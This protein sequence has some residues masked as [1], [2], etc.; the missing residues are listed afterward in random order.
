MK[1]I[2]LGIQIDNF[3]VAPHYKRYEKDHIQFIKGVYDTDQTILVGDFN[4]LAQYYPSN[5]V[6]HFD[7]HGTSSIDRMVSKRIP[8]G[9]IFTEVSVTDHL[10]LFSD[11]YLNGHVIT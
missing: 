8:S 7:N 11:F 1:L 10:A 3:Y 9:E 4:H 5:L 2:D 6:T